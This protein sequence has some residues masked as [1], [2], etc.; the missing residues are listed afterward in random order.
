VP[1]AT[2]AAIVPQS[3]RFVQRFGHR[4]ARASICRQGQRKA[5]AQ[6]SSL[7]N[8]YRIFFGYRF[9]SRQFLYF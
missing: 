3:S 5:Q 2:R 6:T 9:L 7:K 8:S 1:H 4:R